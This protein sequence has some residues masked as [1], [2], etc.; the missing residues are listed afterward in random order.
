MYYGTR[1]QYE[2]NRDAVLWLLNLFKRKPA[3]H[4]D[5]VDHIAVQVTNIASAVAWYRE[6][7]DCEIEWS[8]NDRAMLKFDNV[9]L[10]LV[11]ADRYPAH[12]ALVSDH[13]EKASASTVCVD[14]TSSSYME[15]PWGNCIELLKRP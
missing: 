13:P 12:V 6:R 4:L 2:Q 8:D 10:A 3:S 9:K 5:R 11:K 1:W 7:W 14:G 15:D